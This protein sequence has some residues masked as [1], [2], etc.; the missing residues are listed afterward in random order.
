MTGVRVFGPKKI[1]NLSRKPFIRMAERGETVRPSRNQA[2]EMQRLPGLLR[3]DFVVRRFQI[4][5]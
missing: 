1:V 4:H 5:K 2:M 3:K